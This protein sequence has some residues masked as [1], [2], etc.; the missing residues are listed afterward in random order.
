MKCNSIFNSNE[1]GILTSSDVNK[2]ISC[3]EDLNPFLID[4]N[5]KL[6]KYSICLD[7]INKL[8]LSHFSTGIS[9]D[10]ERCEL[11][12]SSGFAYIDQIKTPYQLLIEGLF[13]WQSYS[14][15]EQLENYLGDTNCYCFTIHKKIDNYILSFH[16]KHLIKRDSLYINNKTL[17]KMMYTVVTHC[18]TD[19]EDIFHKLDNYM[20]DQ[21]IIYGTPANDV[22]DKKVNDQIAMLCED[23]DHSF[24]ITL[25]PQQQNVAKSLLIGRTAKEIANIMGLSQFTVNSYVKDIKLKLGVNFKSDL[26]QM[27]RKHKMLLLA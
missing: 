1:S 21:T 16:F 14:H 2:L 20:V 8:L 27:I 24:N 11:Y 12:Y 13:P 5:N 25:T 6:S 23:L 15:Y 22:S 3:T 9:C 7:Y 19:H 17:N 18:L 26:I 10:I 4:L